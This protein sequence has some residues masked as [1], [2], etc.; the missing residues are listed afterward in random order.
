MYL[1]DDHEPFELR[2]DAIGTSGN[3]STPSVP[4]LF[5]SASISP[6]VPTELLPSGPFHTGISSIIGSFEDQENTNNANVDCDLSILGA[7]LLYKPNKAI[8][9][10][11]EDRI[12]MASSQD[13]DHSWFQNQHRATASI[14]RPS[15]SEQSFHTASRT[16]SISFDLKNITRVFCES[17]PPSVDATQIVR[18]DYIARVIGGYN[19]RRM[20]YWFIAPTPKMHDSLMFHAKKSKR[21]TWAMYL[22]AKLFQALDHQSVEVC[23]PMIQACIAWMDKFGQ[24]CLM[25]S[26]SNKSRNDI[27]EYFLIQLELAFLRFA[28]AD[29]VSAY[30]QVKRALPKFFQL[31]AFNSSLYIE[32]PDG[33]L[34]VS[35]PRALTSPQSELRRFVIYD[36]IGALVLGTPPLVDYGYENEHEEGLDLIRGIPVT[37][38]GVIS[39]INAWRAQ[40]SGTL[41]NW[42]DLERQVLAWKPLSTVLERDPT[43]DYDSI[44]RTTVQEGWRHVALI[45]IYMV[46]SQ[47]PVIHISVKPNVI[48]TTLQGMCRVSSHDSRVQAAVDQILC[49]GET[50]ANLPICVHMFVHY[51]VVS[52]IYAH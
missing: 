12:T 42:Q 5:R 1:K 19:Y 31:V 52:S 44:A 49:L 13:V 2:E 17:I 18:D 40:S 23:G 36:T 37:L 35:F 25:N 15:S 34:V 28:I 46:C 41:G 27:G 3:Q 22:G 4:M 39:Q 50:V 11:N 7:A 47:F 45:Y 38:A 16:T 43:V 9:L 32:C 51:L 14:F 26:R 20:S 21:M 48:E 29:V 8:S 30:N 33:N 24:K 10:Q 6:I